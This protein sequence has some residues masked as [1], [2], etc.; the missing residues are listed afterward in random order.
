MQA[1]FNYQTH[2]ALN[3]IA[4]DDYISMCDQN[5]LTEQIGHYLVLL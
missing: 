4:L 1:Q 5:V 3:Y 2:V